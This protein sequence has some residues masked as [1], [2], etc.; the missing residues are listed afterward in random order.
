MDTT[1]MDWGVEMNVVVSEDPPTVV[2][3]NYE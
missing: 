3:A 1:L 2:E